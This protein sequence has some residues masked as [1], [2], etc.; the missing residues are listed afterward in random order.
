MSTPDPMTPSAAREMRHWTD[1]FLRAYCET[2]P[3]IAVWLGF[4]EYDGR[5]PD[6][7]RRALETRLADLQRFLADLAQID[8]ADLDERAWLDYQVVRHQALL[9][10]FTLAEWR[11]LERDPIPYLETLNVGNYILRNYA[12]LEVRARALLAHLRGVPAVLSAMRENL[13]RP[14]RPAVGVA[15]RLGKGLA[16]FLQDDLPGALVG[17]ED[18]ALRAEL[19]GA[20]RDAVREVE[21]AVSWLENDLA[22]RAT[23]D[24]ALGA[25]TFARMLALS[26]GVDLPLDRL[27]KVAE[28]N[29]ARDKA[30]FLETAARLGGSGRDPNEV[31]AEG[32]RRH[33]TPESLVPE[34]RRLVDELRQTVITRGIVS[35]PYDEN[36]MVAET[37]PFL[38]YAFAMMYDVGPFEPV[39]REAYYYVTPPE[40]DW[41]PE[42]VEEWMTAF[43]YHSLWSTCVHEAWPGHYLHGLHARNAPSAVTKAFGSYAFT[44]GWAH[45]CEQMMW[46]TVCPDDLWARLGQLSEALL[47]DVRFV[48]ALGLHTAG[49]TVEE[50]TRRFVEDAFMEPTPAEEEAIRG[51]YDP[52][53]LNYTLGKLMV[54]KLRED[55]RA[56]EGDRFDLRSFHDRFLSYGTPPVPVV[57]CLMLGADE[58]DVV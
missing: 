5:L 33:P 35:V 12:P 24:F 51:T 42:K 18:G 17:L 3:P 21:A 57:R 7:S 49:M 25:E 52:Q 10:V 14:M 2:Y 23:D 4:H 50:A 26:E 1:A 20:I 28:E 29:L 41:P 30:A 9:E 54:L 48:C 39:A 38:R 11:K 6:L 53:Y 40:P 32:K 36:C 37:P 44:E 16:S 27:R 45:Y 22:S 8:P 34:V 55:A 19:D 43:T 47:R 46:E 56:R 13:T 31:I 15:A 58:G